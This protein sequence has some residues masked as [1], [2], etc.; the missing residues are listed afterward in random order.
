MLYC[1]V[2]TFSLHQIV[3]LVPVDGAW[4]IWLPWVTCSASC[5]PGIQTRLRF[6]N[7][8]PPSFGGKDCNSSDSV[9]TQACYLKECKGYFV[10][11]FI[12]IG[13]MMKVPLLNV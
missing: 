3:F 13:N 11:H 1:L 4:S 2:A 10:K 7:S 6:C 8:P 9:M 12:L 5:G